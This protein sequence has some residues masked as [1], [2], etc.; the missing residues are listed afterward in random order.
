MLNNLTLYFI[1]RTFA[2]ES[3]WSNGLYEK[4]NGIIVDMIHKIRADS[5]YELEL[6]VH[7]GIAAKT[8][9]MNVCGFKKSMSSDGYLHP[10]KLLTH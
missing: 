8:S 4:H 10:C 6:D 9:L 3:A 1:V 2:G 7:W 5:Q